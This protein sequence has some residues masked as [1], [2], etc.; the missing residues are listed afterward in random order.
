[1]SVKNSEGVV[2]ETVISPERARV[3][4]IVVV[5]VVAPI[6]IAVAAPPIFKVVT[7]ELRRLK[8]VAV[9]VRSPPFK[10]K[11]PVKVVS[12]VTVK[13]PD[14][15]MESFK[16]RVADEP[17]EISPPPDKLVPAVTV[18]LLLDRAELGRLVK[19]LLEP[20][21]LLLVKV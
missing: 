10:A 12:P 7:V 1:M 3:L 11:S 17:K 4:L 14:K 13:V 16:D 9:E 8:V 5:P 15:E 20:D 6:E 18:T 19:V 21:M 2:L